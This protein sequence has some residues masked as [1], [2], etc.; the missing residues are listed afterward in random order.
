MRSRLIEIKDLVAARSATGFHV[1]LTFRSS[2]KRAQSCRQMAHQA[3]RQQCRPRYPQ[4]T[5]VKIG[6]R[7]GVITEPKRCSRQQARSL[8]RLRGKL[9]GQAE[10]V[11]H[12]SDS[13]ILRCQCVK[14]VIYD[15]RPPDRSLARRIARASKAEHRLQQ[16]LAALRS[17]LEP[18]S[19]LT[20]M[21]P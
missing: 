10:T 2:G 14:I 7:V 4:S 16:S 18:W 17:T 8:R 19:F 20:L 15:H 9:T 11:L 6:P 12:L 1:R 5:L 3:D 13:T 21:A